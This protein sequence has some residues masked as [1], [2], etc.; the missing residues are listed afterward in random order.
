M[1]SNPEHSSQQGE[2]QKPPKV[3]HFHPYS[4]AKKK[5]DELRSQ[6]TQPPIPNGG[7]HHTATMP[8]MAPHENRHQDYDPEAALGSIPDEAACPM[9]EHGGGTSTRTGGESYLPQYSGRHNDETVQGTFHSTGAGAAT[10]DGSH[11]LNSGTENTPLSGNPARPDVTSEFQSES[12]HG[13]M[14]GSAG[15]IPAGYQPNPQPQP[16]DSLPDDTWQTGQ[17]AELQDF[18]HS[19]NQPEVQGQNVRFLQIFRSIELQPR[20]LQAS[21]PENNPQQYSTTTSYNHG[22]QQQVPS[23]YPQLIE[24]WALSERGYLLFNGR[25]SQIDSPKSAYVDDMNVDLGLDYE[26]VTMPG[27]Y[28]YSGPVHTQASYSAFYY[29]NAAPNVNGGYVN[30]PPRRTDPPKASS[31]N[32]KRKH[33]PA[34]NQPPVTKNRLY[35]PPSWEE[36]YKQA[37]QHLAMA[38]QQMRHVEGINEQ[39]IHQMQAVSEREK[40]QQRNAIRQLQEQI[41]AQTAR[42]ARLERDNRNMASQLMPGLDGYDTVFGDPPNETGFVRNRM[43]EMGHSRPPTS[44]A[45]GG[46]AAPPNGTSAVDERRQRAAAIIAG[47]REQQARAQPKPRN[48]RGPNPPLLSSAR[49]Q[50]SVPMRSAPGVANDM[51]KHITFLSSPDLPTAQ[52]SRPGTNIPPTSDSIAKIWEQL[53][54]MQTETTNQLEAI[55]REIQTVRRDTTKRR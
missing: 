45:S 31:G 36:K 39:R 32:M 3:N 16:M 28:P 25:D 15:G 42:M 53:A 30:T 6:A 7:P 18:L 35:M 8:H 29:D 17:D 46:S 48:L 43:A 40:E 20:K 12:P 13:T 41:E 33:P 22:Y 44:S 49:Q 38:D 52:L 1:P 11:G 9:A 34:G 50:D 19:I 54:K 27:Q 24:V 2:P 37:E 47:R 5:K 14:P 23:I 51:A 4:E 10:S 26:R 55:K 21:K